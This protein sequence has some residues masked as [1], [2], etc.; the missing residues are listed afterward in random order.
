[1]L[2][3]TLM[4]TTMQIQLLAMLTVR[5]SHNQK[6]QQRTRTTVIAASIL[7]YSSPYK[8]LKNLKPSTLSL[9]VSNSE[10]GTLHRNDSITLD[11]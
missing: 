7:L 10:L 3:V 2:A 8:T 1:M 9:G 4:A 11:L 6:Y 5:K